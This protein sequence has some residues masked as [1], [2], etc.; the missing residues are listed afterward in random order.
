MSTRRM[1]LNF[2][3][4]SAG[5]HAGAWSP[6]YSREDGQ[7]GIAFYQD[8]AKTAERGR[9][10]AVFFADG[11]ALGGEERKRP[12][13]DPIVLTAALAAVT[14]RIGLVS[15]ASTTFSEPYTLARQFATLDHLSRGRIGWNVVT[16]YDRNAAGNFGQKSLPP[17]EERYARAEEFVDVVKALWNGWD[18][19]SLDAKEGDPNAPHP[20]DHAGTYFQVRGPLQL[21]RTPQGY[22]V[23][24]QAGG[25]PEGR[26]LAARHA[27]GTFVTAHTIEDGRESYSAFKERV[28][29]FGRNPDELKVMPGVYVY[30]VG[31]DAEVTK[32]WKVLRERAPE[33]A[34][35]RLL[36][37]RLGVSPASLDLDH[38]VPE[39]VLGEAHKHA[40]SRGQTDSIVSTLRRERLTVREWI[41]R[42]PPV[43]PHR[44]IVGTP[45]QVAED[46]EVWFQAEAADGFNVGNLSPSGLADF[47]DHVI[48]IL[49]KRQLF[50]FDYEGDTLRSHYS[51]Q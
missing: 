48:P 51:E 35:V 7:F 25:S 6:P 50:R 20:I 46:L 39:A 44:V 29:A 26:D 31:S 37:A 19:R 43:G 12:V 16:S 10:D 21:P 11:L 5:V 30:L 27:N 13:C 1:K 33:A 32:Q 42:Q 18:Y 49:Q 28:R 22:P 47:V 23:L 14:E 36:A 24:F 3:A 41:Q 34:S 8:L 9:F 45:E 15:S 2:H 4:N 38:T 17:R 40:I